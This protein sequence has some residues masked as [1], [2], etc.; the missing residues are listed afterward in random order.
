MSQIAAWQN[1]VASRAS[2]AATTQAPVPLAVAAA[3]TSALVAAETAS[4]SSD[5]VIDVVR[6]SDAARGAASA[7]PAASVPASAR[8]YSALGVGGGDEGAGML[9]A[10]SAAY[11]AAAFWDEEEEEEAVAFAARRQL[12]SQQG[13]RMVAAAAPRQLMPK[14]TDSSDVL[15]RRR[16]PETWEWYN[17]QEFTERFSHVYSEVELR[18]YWLTQCVVERKYDEDWEVVTWRAF[19]AKHALGAGGGQASISDLRRQ[20]RMLQWVPDSALPEREESVGV[21]GGGPLAQDRANV[22]AHQLAPAPAQRNTVDAGREAMSAALA[23]RPATKPDS[24]DIE[25]WLSQWESAAARDGF[26]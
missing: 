4:V 3:T 6:P 10:A 19:R 8:A 11:M 18:H 17:F 25:D 9:S 13:S 22:F 5:E 1:A 24:D 2:P 14:G 7:P 16:D 26:R 21:D 12:P 23:N 15:E 20:W